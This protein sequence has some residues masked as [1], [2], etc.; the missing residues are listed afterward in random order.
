MIT[1]NSSGTSLS[2]NYGTAVKEDS[3]KFLSA[4]YM[5]G[6]E[7]NCAIT[8]LEITKGSCGSSTEFSVGN[9]ISSTLTA[10]VKELNTNVKGKIVE[11][12]IG[13]EVN[14]TYEWV[15][16]G[17]FR[18]NEVKKTVYTT[19][20]TGHGR[21]VS[22]SNGAFNVPTPQTLTNIA[23]N[24]GTGL[25]CTVTLGTGINGALEVAEPMNG[26]TDYQ[27]LQVLTSVVG[28]YAIDTYD[29]N[30]KVCLFDDTTTHSVNSGMMNALPDVEESDFSIT[31][32]S[33]I[34]TEA[35]SDEDGEIPAV[36]YTQG[37]VNLEMKN[38]YMTGALF[39]PMATALIGYT[40][41]PATI[42]LA[43]GD[44]RIEGNDVLQV[45]D[46]NN[47]VYTVPC[48]ILKHTYDGGFSTSIDSVRA[49]NSADSIGVV[50]PLQTMLQEIQSTIV[51]VN[52]QT[53]I[54]YNHA[55]EHA[56]D[57]ITGGLGGYVTIVRNSDGQ[58]TEIV[59]ADNIDLTQ[60]TN[61]WRWNQ[62]GIGYSSTGYNGT[63]ATA[64]TMDGHF[65][66]DYI[67][68]GTISDQANKNYWNLGTGQFVTKQGTIGNF[69]IDVSGLKYV[70]YF[71]T[72]K[73]TIYGSYI[74]SE[75]D[76]RGSGGFYAGQRIIQGG[77]DCRYLVSDGTLYGLN[78]SGLAG[79][80][81]H[82]T[83]SV[84]DP[85]TSSQTILAGMYAT[86]NAILVSGA[87]T[88]TGN[89][90]VAGTKSRQVETDNY[91]DRVLYCYETPVPLFGDIGEAII[92]EDGFCYIDLDDIFSETVFDKGEYQVFLQKEGEGDCWVSDKNPRYFVIQGTPNLKVAWE[93]KAKQKGYHNIR[94][95]MADYGLDEYQ[96]IEF[97]IEDY[98]AEQ[99]D[100]LYG[101]Y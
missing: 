92:D 15:T 7:V 69:T 32:V 42:N 62:N 64:W 31:G 78:I 3:R 94:L 91:S 68:S 25:G 72:S 74:Q 41:R 81:F 57:L 30:V 101:N 59:I 6:A 65:V 73:T 47:S 48:H 21:I 98:V 18:I 17:K 44:P 96:N 12:R 71:G 23:S 45:T 43:L 61:V 49:T 29:G 19:T 16:L 37:T 27:A 34:V 63:F 56:T 100:L 39:T 1:K 52:S 82:R 58:P 93:L 26:L 46:V 86:T 88:V 35:S 54:N 97:N 85:W 20:L 80:V 40:Y 22:D 33:C 99:E 87:L 66:A 13:L 14:G 2:A 38:K 70:D 84:T 10:E 11:A 28:G 8:R 76:L 51:H 79:I 90:V 50:T 9:L 4:I 83:T 36:G 53:E 60:A 77:T 67:Y 95:E 55:I 75:Y 89:L 24:I 5:N